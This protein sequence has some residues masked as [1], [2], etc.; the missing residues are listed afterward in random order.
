MRKLTAFAF[1]VLGAPLWWWSCWKIYFKLPKSLPMDS[2]V[3]ASLQL[4]ED[5]ARPFTFL[6][7]GWCVLGLA[8]NGIR[9]ARMERYRQRAPTRQGYAIADFGVPHCRFETLGGD[10]SFRVTLRNNNY[11]ATGCVLS[12]FTVPA[13]AIL[14]FFFGGLSMAFLVILTITA[15]AYLFS[16]Y[17]VPS[18]IEVHPDTIVIN[19]V[20]LERDHFGSFNIHGRSQLGYE[21]GM[22]NYWFPGTWS[23]LEVTEMA[24]ALNT[25]ISIR[26]GT[27]TPAPT[28]EDLREKRRPDKY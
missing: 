18:H 5:Y 1:I 13:L 28:P 10:G 15:A 6:F 11:S 19:G 23:T 7:V 14:Y 22:R 25:H 4:S 12:V 20:P 9:N 24:S 16:F 27:P 26:P 17:R 8:R 21:Y 2:N 3:A